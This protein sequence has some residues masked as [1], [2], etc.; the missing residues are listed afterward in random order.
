[1]APRTVG[2]YELRVRRVSTVSDAPTISTPADATPIMQALTADAAEE[3]F[4][5]V[6]LDSRHRITGSQIVSIGSLNASI[7][8]PREVFRTAILHGAARIII[9]HNHPSGDPTPS[10][11]D[12]KLNRRLVEAG[13]LL[14]I[15]VLDHII[16]GDTC[17]SFKERGIM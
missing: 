12:I 4:I 6:F 17:I 15:E 10:S 9:G 14:G 7:V 3:R 16:V 2:L 8:H 1:M 11:D 13:E 5:A